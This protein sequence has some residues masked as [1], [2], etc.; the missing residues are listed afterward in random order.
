M[1]EGGGREG[2]REITGGSNLRTYVH[3][4][5]QVVLVTTSAPFVCKH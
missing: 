3:T 1:K 5:I 4:Y 2:E